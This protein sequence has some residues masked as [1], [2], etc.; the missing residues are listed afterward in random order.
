MFHAASA[1]IVFSEPNVPGSV[2]QVDNNG[3]NVELIGS[4]LDA[5]MGVKLGCR[6]FFA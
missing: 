4:D 3:Q 5:P 1:Q 2:Y 6:L